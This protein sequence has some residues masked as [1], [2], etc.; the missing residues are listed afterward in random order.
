MLLDER[1]SLDH[2]DPKGLRVYQGSLDPQA[3]LDSQ[4]HLGPQGYLLRGN[5]GRQVLKVCVGKQGPKE[6]KEI[7]VKMAKQGYLVPLEL[8]VFQA[9]QVKRDIRERRGLGFPVSRGLV[10]SQ[11]RREI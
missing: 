6:T 2:Q 10:E 11:G 1:E 3:C 8:M 7:M 9:S 5:M 4:V